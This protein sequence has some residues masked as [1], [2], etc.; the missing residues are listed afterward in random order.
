HVQVMD[1]FG[2][3]EEEITASVS[4]KQTQA[5]IKFSKKLN[6]GKHIVNIQLIGDNGVYD[7]YSLQF[8]TDKIAEIVSVENQ[9]SEIPVGEK[10][11]ST[12]LLKSTNLVNGTLTARLYDN[13]D[14]LVDEHVRDVSLQGEKSFNTTLNSDNILTNLGKS[15]FFLSVNG[16]Q[17]DH[18]VQEIFIMQPRL[19]DDYD[20][21]MY[22]FGPNPIPG[23]W[24]AVDRQLQELNVTTLAAYTLSNSKHANYKVQA[25]TR[26]QGVESPDSGP[27]LEYYE[28]MLIKYLETHD[29]HLLIRKYGLKDTVYL[30]SVRKDLTAQLK[31]WKKFS[32]SA[33]YIYE[34]PS[35]TRYDG[36]LDLD[37]SE[38]SLIAMRA[39]LKEQYS[40]LKTLN[41]QWGTNFTQWA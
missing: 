16:N 36:A 30:N 12:I 22:H 10:V 17:T 24:S 33:Y 39:W 31:A 11:Q 13:Y 4:S 3:I 37:F 29:K 26:I 5:D 2:V 8:Q 20:V 40:S 34:E 25:Q 35:I 6:G 15:E 28:E 27:D 19:W 21:T 9:K 38:I 23:I 7:W 14:R 1:D 41:D 18:E 32:P